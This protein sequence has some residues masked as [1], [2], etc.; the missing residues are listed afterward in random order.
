MVKPSRARTTKSRLRSQPRRRSNAPVALLAAGVV[1]FGLVA[2]WVFHRR[3]AP[4]AE[5]RGASSATALGSSSPSSTDSVGAPDQA[6]G[7]GAAEPGAA[8][9]NDVVG[10]SPSND[11]GPN[12]V[13]IVTGPLARF[14]KAAEALKRGRRRE[15]VRVL[16]LGD[17]HTFADFWPDAVRRPLADRF[18][19]GGPGF[20]FTGLESYRHAGAHF[21][22]SGDWTVRPDR[23]SLPE[24]QDD[25][26]FGLGGMRAVAESPDSSFKIDVERDGI[27]GDATWDLC[28]RLPASSSG[29]RI[30]GDGMKPILVD[31][32]SFHVGRLEHVTWR[33]PAPASVTV[34]G[35]DGAPEFCGVVV[36]GTVPGIVLDS[37]GIIGSRIA[38]ALSWDETQWI[39]EAKRRHPVLAVL[40]YGTNEC[41]DGVPVAKY[42]A[43]YTQMMQR[44]RA[45]A[46]DV[47]C[48][49]V[50]PTDR[51]VKLGSPGRVGQITA[52]QQQAAASL[53]CAFFSTQDAMGGPGGFTK[54]ASVDGDFTASDG[55]HLAPNG[56]AELGAQMVRV[57]LSERPGLPS[58]K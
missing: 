22:R 4:S 46:P 31:S 18:G 20:F 27:R 24:R 40:A 35:T 34:D 16:W 26:I 43:Q 52:V 19:A 15:P 39:A 14:F 50:G 47:D 8:P 42:A 9:S 38:T 36:E 12:D 1:L 29:F 49:I 53:G 28:F 48:V 58:L 56:Y 54:W 2:G 13:A 30:Q 23:P 7:A 32:T 55:V 17:S 6:S 11:A 5:T 45:A 3:S 37:V 57:L 51:V 44:L 33:T 21:S 10:S 25:G 41:G